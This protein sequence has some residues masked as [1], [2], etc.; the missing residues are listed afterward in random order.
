MLAI[1]A[2]DAIAVK[3]PMK[4]PKY[5]QIAPALPP[6]LITNSEALN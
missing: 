3:K 5:T 2:M 4:A 1:S 6:F